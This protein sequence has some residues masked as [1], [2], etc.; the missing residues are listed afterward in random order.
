M[1]HV[2]TKGRETHSNVEHKGNRR[3][4]NPRGSELDELDGLILQ[5][6]DQDRWR[7]GGRKRKESASDARARTKAGRKDEKRTARATNQNQPLQ[8]F[9]RQSLERSSLHTHRLDHH[10]SVELEE[11]SVVFLDLLRGNV[12]GG[13]EAGEAC[14]PSREGREDPSN[15]E[16][17]GVGEGEK[18]WDM[19]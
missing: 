13:G 17:E 3:Q 9:L 6:I 11:L 1:K 14:R 4:P 16:D 2:R 10:G 5:H 12:G 15:E 18:A 8:L 19:E 7:K